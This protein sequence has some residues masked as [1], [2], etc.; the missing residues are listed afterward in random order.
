[1]ELADAFTHR[2]N[3]DTYEELLG[4]GVEPDVLPIE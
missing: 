4:V 1:M 2:Y 3:I